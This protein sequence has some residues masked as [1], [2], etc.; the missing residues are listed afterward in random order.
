MLG[1]SP[2]SLSGC[3]GY[4]SLVKEDVPGGECVV[5]WLDAYGWKQ[6]R[7]VVLR[8]SSSPM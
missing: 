2:D 6:V 1:S 7:L 8:L 3:V 4:W 5:V